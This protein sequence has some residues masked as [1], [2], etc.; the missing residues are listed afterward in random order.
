MHLTQI[1]LSGCYLASEINL[2]GNSDIFKLTRTAFGT[3][4]DPWSS[5]PVRPSPV[6]FKEANFA[7]LVESPKCTRTAFGTRVLAFLKSAN[8]DLINPTQKQ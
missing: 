1:F 5:F 8:H 2:W 3:G 7:V 6:V 4:N